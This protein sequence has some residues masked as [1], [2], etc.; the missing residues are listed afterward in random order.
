MN[1][2]TVGRSPKAE[3][4]RLRLVAP[5]EGGGAALTE[6]SSDELVRLAQAGDAAAIDALVHRYQAKLIRVAT[7]YL[8]EPTL[9]WDA[10]QQALATV[11]VYRLHQY[12]FEQKFQAYLFAVL[13][14]EC[15]QALRRRKRE[16]DLRSSAV[17]PV[18]AS[19]RVEESLLARRAVLGLAPKLREVVTLR[20]AGGL[21][22]QEISD[23]LGIRVA[24]ARRR[25]FDAM[26]KL[27]RYLEES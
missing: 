21:S 5:A 8:D 1:P 27:Q 26:D 11:L 19:P 22:F 24:T 18:A 2:V 25:H 3:A 7:R 12:R 6:L 23:V 13:I 16:R 15:R 14:N 10:V 4:V 20:Y 17:A 9:A